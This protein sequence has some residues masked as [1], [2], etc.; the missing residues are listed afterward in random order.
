MA[1]G[2]RRHDG[3]PEY[4]LKEVHT[5]AR[6]SSIHFTTKAR[7]EATMLLPSAVGVPAHAIRN[8]LLSLR[9]E[10]WRF[11]ERNDRGC[12]DVYR[13]EKFDR[14]IWVKLKV[15]M[16]LSRETVILISFHRFDDE[17]PV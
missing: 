5:L 15:E 4:E 12:V 14:V 6:L 1:R 9:P 8:T 16:R 13:I 10:H 3:G 7:D 2:E 17:I 11:A